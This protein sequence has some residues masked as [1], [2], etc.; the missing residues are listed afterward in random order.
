MLPERR[1]PA[2]DGKAALRASNPSVVLSVLAVESFD[3][4]RPTREPRLPESLPA[5][6]VRDTTDKLIDPRHEKLQN[7]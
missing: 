4:Q 1:T 3:E 2:F 7:R 6:F 5:R